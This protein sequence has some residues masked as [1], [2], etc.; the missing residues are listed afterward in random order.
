MKEGVLLAPLTTLGVGGKA[1]VF[2]EVSTEQELEVAARQASEKGL[3]LLPLGSGSNL[4]VP[5]EGV[6]GVVIKVGFGG[7]EFDGET[8]TVGAGVSWNAIVDASAERNLFGIENL[9]GIP[10][11][12][13]G[14]LVQNIGAYGAELSNVF[15]SADV[16]NAT[17]GERSRMSFADAQFGYR[18]SVFKSRPELII[19]RVTL[20][21]RSSGMSDLSYPDLAKA[22][23]GGVPLS[24][25]REVGSAVRAI[26]ARKFPQ[27]PEE[28]TAGSFFKN[29]VL[30]EAHARELS[31]RYQGLPSFPQ[32][33]GGTKVSLAW[34]LDKALTLKGY[35]IGRA[36]LYEEQP[37]VIVTEKG[38]TAKEVDA[39]ARDVATR[40]HEETRVVVEREVETFGERFSAR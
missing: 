27:R 31:E 33:S 24:A 29:P 13:G 38:A 36:R 39:L 19:E 4:L 14:A 25:P 2:C 9:A 1:R 3:P 21:L 30:A 11:T 20:A 35:R 5:D 8:V 12:V 23:D 37:L 22:Q 10:G 32:R 15:A 18:S 34:I 17:T 26:R 7:I 16:F 28:G 40:V 6:E